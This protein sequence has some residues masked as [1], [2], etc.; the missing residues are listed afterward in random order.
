[1]CGCVCVCVR[2]QGVY[3]VLRAEGAVCVADEVQCG[4]GRVGE[5][6]WGFETQ[7]VLPDIVTLGKPMGEC[8]TTHTHTHTHTHVHQLHRLPS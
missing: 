3:D 7:S 2:V 5:C 4:F 1:M 8:P 6:F